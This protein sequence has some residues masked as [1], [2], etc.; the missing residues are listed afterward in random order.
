[1]CLFFTESDHVSLL[2][3]EAFGKGIADVCF[4]QTEVVIQQLVNHVELQVFLK[5]SQNSLI[6]RV[7]MHQVAHEVEVVL[8]QITEVRDLLTQVVTLLLLELL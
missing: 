7:L 1:M 3:L 8:V 4:L 5:L 6:L 2:L